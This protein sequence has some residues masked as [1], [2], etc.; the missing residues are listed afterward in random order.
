[1]SYLKSLTYIW[2]LRI[3]LLLVIDPLKWDYTQYSIVVL[4][5]IFKNNLSFVIVF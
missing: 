5:H 2:Q 1:M 4:W 3:K